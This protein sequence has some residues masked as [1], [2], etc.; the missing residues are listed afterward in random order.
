MSDK[1]RLF[2]ALALLLMLTTCLMS[3]CSDKKEV[4]VQN[5]TTTSQ[6]DNDIN[7]DWPTY[8]VAVEP[9]YAP[10]AF[11]DANGNVI[12][13]DEDILR[14]IGKIEQ[15]NVK[16]VPTK[17]DGIFN[18]L[19]T[20]SRDIVA[21]GTALTPERAKHWGYTDA[22]SSDY[23][24]FVFDEQSGIK[25]LDDLKGKT[26]A[27]QSDT[28]L[29]TF[30]QNTYGKSLKKIIVTPTTYLAFED[31]LRGKA[32][33]AY[34]DEPVIRYYIASMPDGYY[35]GKLKIIVEK[36]DNLSSD[37]VFYVAKSNTKLRDKLNNGIRAIK[38]NGEFA[39]INK[40]WF[41]IEE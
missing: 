37:G 24:A 4:Q 17:W 21:S 10:F 40:K 22:I 20:G 32:D 19:D 11:R 18:H 15:F 38:K 6:A 31:M 3:G 35:D 13:F 36:N 9:S 39:K 8:S 28:A 14:A 12:G 26:I 5:S 16:F 30:L 7:P 29:L 1:I 41:G 2:S 33:V 34:L 25:T 27:V 23:S